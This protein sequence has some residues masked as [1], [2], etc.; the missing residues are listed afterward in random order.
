MIKSVLKLL[1]PPVFFL[2]FKKFKNKYFGYLF[3]GYYKSPEDI[4]RIS[5]N[6]EYLTPAQHRE[7]LKNFLNKGDKDINFNIRNLILPLF[8]SDKENLNFDIL[9]IGGGFSSCYKYIK[10]STQKKINVTVLE[11]VEI[12][13]SIV[14]FYNKNNDILYLTKLPSEPKKY[15]ILFYGSSFQYFLYFDDIVN[16]ILLT[17]PIYIIIAESAFTN[18]QENIFSFQVNMYPSMIPYKINSLEKLRKKFENLGYSLIFK[19][20]RKIGNH[21]HISNNK[22][23]TADLIFKKI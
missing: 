13:D 18:N 21:R 20:K 7:S 16:N 10:F 19:T 3:W 6:D 17:E 23:Y 4:L 22:I 1:I 11:R 8:L 2:L 15:D 12:V 14:K 5:K 9:D